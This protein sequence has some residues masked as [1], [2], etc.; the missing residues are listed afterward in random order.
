MSNYQ[1]WLCRG[2]NHTLIVMASFYFVAVSLVRDVTYFVFNLFPSASLGVCSIVLSVQS[3][4]VNSMYATYQ[5]KAVTKRMMMSIVL[6][7]VVDTTLMLLN[8]SVLY[9]CANISI[10]LSVRGKYSS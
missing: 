9:C 2:S 5:Q 6:S 1:S 10:A 8:G 3:C 7:S 4:M